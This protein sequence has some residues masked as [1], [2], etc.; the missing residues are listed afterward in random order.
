MGEHKYTSDGKKVLIVGKLNAQE[1]I[2]QEI[3]VSGEQEIPSG[4][5]FVVKS[6][7]DNPSVSWKEKNLVDL[8]A[9]Y[10]RD[11]NQLEDKL[12]KTTKTLNA[13]ID[14]AYKRSVNLFQFAENAK[15]EQLDLLKDFLGGKITHYAIIKGY[16]PEIRKIDDLQNFDYDN[17]YGSVK[18]EALKLISLFGSS[19]GDL[20]WKMNRYRD[21]SGDW[22]EI[23]PCRSYE[24]ALKHIQKLFDEVSD[25]YLSN[26][27]KN[28]S[29]DLEK[30]RVFDGIEISEEII[31]AQRST[32]ALNL[33]EKIK[34]MQSD[35]K[36]EEELLLTLNKQ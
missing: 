27:G 8:E 20:S 26:E 19:N 7:H 14:K 4:E 32:N 16:S 29:I 31:E 24:E 17:Y 10:D 13:N 34:K 33:T 2:V 22:V 18:I 11:K 21:G 23:V 35:L 30:W 1:T 28:R 36:K 3:F 15:D 25:K 12:K 9:R 6:L 5:N